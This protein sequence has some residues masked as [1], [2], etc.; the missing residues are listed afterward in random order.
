VEFK[1][2]VHGAGF[3]VFIDQGRL[4]VLEGFTYD[5]D[6]PPEGTPWLVRRVPITRLPPE[7][8]GPD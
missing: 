8:G 7:A 5:E 6:W 2:L 3:V 1:G 4:A